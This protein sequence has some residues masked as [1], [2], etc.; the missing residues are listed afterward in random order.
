M[1]MTFLVNTMNV[2]FTAHLR[3]TIHL[4]FEE[5]SIIFIDDHKFWWHGVTC[6]CP[7]KPILVDVALVGSH[8]HWLC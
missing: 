8:A 5:C 7:R 4:P 1:I 2:T 3:T 6:P